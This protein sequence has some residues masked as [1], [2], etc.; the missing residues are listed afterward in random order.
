MLIIRIIRPKPEVLRSFIKVA[1]QYGFR[2]MPH[3]RISLVFLRI[4]PLYAGVCKK[5]QFR[6]RMES[7]NLH[8][9]ASGNKKMSPRTV[10]LSLT[11]ANSTFRKILVQ[12]LKEGM[13]KVQSGCISIWMSVIAVTK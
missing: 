11:L 3:V 10:M 8:R 1:H 6:D 4:H 12:Q 7:G 2:V 5:F 13:G 9:M